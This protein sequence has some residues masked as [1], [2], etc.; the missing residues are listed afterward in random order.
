MR[1]FEYPIYPAYYFMKNLFT[2]LLCCHAVVLNAQDISG[3]YSGKLTNDSTHKEQQYELAL[4]EYRGQIS[5]YAYTTFFV[6]D[7]FYYSVKRVKAKRNEGGLLVEDVKMLGHNFPQAPDKGVRQVMQIPLNKQDSI[8]ELKGSWKTTQTKIYHAIG[9]SLYLKRDADSSQSALVRHLY[10]MNELQQSATAPSPN[11]V[12]KLKNKSNNTPLNTAPEKLAYTNRKE[13]IIETF[14]VASDSLVLSFYDNGIVDGDTISVYLNKQ[15][16]ISNT[17]LTGAAAR[18]VIR[19]PKDVVVHKLMLV[20]EN[21]GTIPP[22]T[23]LLIIQ[24]GDNRYQVHFTAD[25]QTNAVIELRNT[26]ASEKLAE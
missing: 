23:G 20:A 8:V 21:L 5:G 19:L 7:T 3:L 1:C 26:K 14:A 11:A 6:R 17:K 10:D 13:H 18:Q 12:V 16:I 15:N 25:L 9:G 22:N 2:L 24:D 4:S